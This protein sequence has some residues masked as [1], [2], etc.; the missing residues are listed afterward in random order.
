MSSLNTLLDVPEQLLATH[1]RLRMNGFP[2]VSVVN[3]RSQLDARVWLGQ[4]AR[5][6]GRALI[7]APETRLEAAIAAYCARLPGGDIASV[8]HAANAPVLCIPGTFQN[9]LQASVALSS[10]HPRLPIAVACGIAE[11]VDSLLNPAMPQDLVGA[12]LQGL[13]PVEEEERHV[14]KTVADARQVQPFL[15]GAC[16]GLVY[17]MLEARPETRGRFSTN[18]RLTN[19]LNS[20]RHEV[21]LVCQEARLVIEIDGP[22]HNQQVRKNMDAKKQK[23]LETQG[24]R[25]Q[26]FRNQTVIED[27]VGVWKMIAQLM[28]VSTA[29][30][31]GR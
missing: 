24:Y 2:V 25:V 29:M 9:A 15:R 16:E 30:E 27:P 21:D 8:Q 19:N 13:I 20:R 31:R 17:Y 5:A 3:A 11:M 22:E 12:A 18:A 1:D 28:S 26:R 14:L 23:D 4:W 6:R 10:L 7:L